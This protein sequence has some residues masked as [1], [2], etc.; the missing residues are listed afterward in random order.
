MSRDT[1]SQNQA[2]TL[3]IL[4][5]AR[6]LFLSKLI[7]TEKQ[8]I[9][10]SENTSVMDLFWN[11]VQTWK[12]AIPIPSI[13]FLYIPPLPEAN[14]STDLGNE[15]LIN[16]HFIQLI[17]NLKHHLD[18]IH[19]SIG[20]F[21]SERSEKEEEEAYF[22]IAGKTFAEAF[23]QQSL[24][25][26]L[27]REEI[28]YHPLSTHQANEIIRDIQNDALSQCACEYLV[29]SDDHTVLHKARYAQCYTQSARKP[30]ELLEDDVAKIKDQIMCAQKG[31][32]KKSIWFT[33]EPCEKNTEKINLYLVGFLVE[34]KIQFPV[35][36]FA[37]TLSCSGVTNLK[38]IEKTFQ[39]ALSYEIAKTKL[40]LFGEM[41]KTSCSIRAR[42]LQEI[43]SNIKND[44]FH[45]RICNASIEQIHSTTTIAGPVIMNIGYDKKTLPRTF[46]L[47][48]KERAGEIY[49]HAQDALPIQST[50]KPFSAALHQ[51]SESAAQPSGY[52]ASV[53]NTT[54]HFSM[55]ETPLLPSTNH[56]PNQSVP[57]FWEETKHH[58]N[59]LKN[60]QSF[61]PDESPERT[62]SSSSGNRSD[63]SDFFESEPTFQLPENA[64]NI[65]KT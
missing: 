42:K 44:T 48:N 19:F 62:L 8:A 58:L 53:D 34:L 7:E 49:H 57:L 5:E 36:E 52:C 43:I 16:P 11:T 17:K 51:S 33:I 24:K 40:T 15:N 3:L 4:I 9:T 1:F 26:I 20:I 64:E 46:Q 60:M 12:T 39:D 14:T 22:F 65:P 31:D 10:A 50:S 41:Q 55:I 54:T 18:Q 30:G 2:Q 38:K 29:I 47:V 61:N 37:V 28:L 25:N 13:P 59:R 27:D 6:V 23:M 63:E 45:V 32:V 56:A 35:V 21:S